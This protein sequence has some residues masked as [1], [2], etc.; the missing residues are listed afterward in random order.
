MDTIWLRIQ[1]KFIAKIL[2][3][4]LEYLAQPA[5]CNETKFII[6]IRMI[7]I[8]VHS[9]IKIVML[10][11]LYSISTIWKKKLIV[12]SFFFFFYSGDEKRV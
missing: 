11:T 4:F 10:N 12:E 3:I 8:A 5:F 1:S 6:I 9:V 2:L 7:I